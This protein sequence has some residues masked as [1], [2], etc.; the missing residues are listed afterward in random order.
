[1]EPEP[2]CET[3]CPLLSRARSPEPKVGEFS[4]GAGTSITAGLQRPHKAGKVGSFW[5]SS[6]HSSWSQRLRALHHR[7]NLKTVPGKHKAD[8]SGSIDEEFY[9]LSEAVQFS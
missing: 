1:M 6:P 4:S 7:T 9:V 8:P 2:S 3:R 5:L